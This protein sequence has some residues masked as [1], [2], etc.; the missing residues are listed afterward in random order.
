MDK[1]RFIDMLDPDKFQ[2]TRCKL[3][4]PKSGMY[5]IDAEK[6]F[7]LSGY[8]DSNGHINICASCQVKVGHTESIVTTPK[9]Y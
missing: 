5:T 9:D 1:Q 8:A 4:R 3:Y 2:C 7:G 6:I